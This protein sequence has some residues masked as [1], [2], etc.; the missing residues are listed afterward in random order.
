MPRVVANAKTAIVK[1]AYGEVRG[2]IHD[3]IYNYKGVQYA[4]AQRFM[5]PEAPEPWTGVR[6]ALS[7][8]KVC[9][10]E[11]PNLLSGRDRVRAAAPLGLRDRGLPAPERLDA[12]HQRREEAPVMV[13]MHGG[14]YSGGS[15]IELRSTTA[16]TSPA[17][18]TSS[19][20]A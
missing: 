11:I 18:A 4:R 3:G 12:G 1:T 10:I 5:A 17:P 9:P 20:S 14:G 15:S 2:F 13:W 16:R 6:T 8:V 19:S 7:D